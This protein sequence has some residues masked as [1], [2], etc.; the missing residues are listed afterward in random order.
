MSKNIKNNLFHGNGIYYI[1]VLFAWNLTQMLLYFITFI[2][3]V[4]YTIQIIS[5]Q[6]YS[7]KQEII[8]IDAT[9]I[10]TI[11]YKIMLYI[12]HK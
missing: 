5:M 7:E 4:L 6:L 1:I 3:I 8:I 11:M 9:R 12:I 2:Y 10:Q